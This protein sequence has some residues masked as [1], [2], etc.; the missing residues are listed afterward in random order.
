MFLTQCLVLVLQ[1]E[2]YRIVLFPCDVLRLST[3]SRDV[4]EPAVDGNFNT[5]PCI[6]GTDLHKTGVV[7]CSGGSSL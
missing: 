5:T 1:Q 4:H 6:E 7:F 2:E 3:G